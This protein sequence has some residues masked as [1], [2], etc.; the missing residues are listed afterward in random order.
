MLSMAVPEDTKVH[1]LFI[2]MMA[3]LMYNPRLPVVAAKSHFFHTDQVCAY[4]AT[5]TASLIA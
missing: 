3:G 1:F 5:T 4:P 2:S